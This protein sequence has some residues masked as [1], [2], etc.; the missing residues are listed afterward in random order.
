M[1]LSKPLTNDLSRAMGTWAALLAEWLE[2]VPPEKQALLTSALE[3][4]CRVAI[5][6]EPVTKAVAF[7]LFEPDGR[8]QR[9][10]LLEFVDSDANRE[11]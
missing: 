9:L 1:N 10:G 7:M 2:Q 6:F 11:R 8:V 3:N 5:E 4:Q